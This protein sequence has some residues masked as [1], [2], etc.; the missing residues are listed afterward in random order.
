[1]EFYVSD[2]WGC[3]RRL[4]LDEVDIGKF[5][6]KHYRVLTLFW[7]VFLRLPP[8]DGF[9]RR[10]PEA[11]EKIKCK[12]VT[13]LSRIYGSL[14]TR[15]VTQVMVGG[16]IRKKGGG[17]ATTSPNPSWERGLT[18]RFRRK[19]TFC[20][21]YQKIFLIFSPTPTFPCKPNLFKSLYTDI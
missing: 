3:S 12:H 8:K 10:I 5:T 15:N 21:I 2:L 18:K 16:K 4:V 7:T 6:I 11:L 14:A 1:M 9:R 19:K 20:S 17:G 13:K